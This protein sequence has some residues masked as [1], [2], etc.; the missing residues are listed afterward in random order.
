MKILFYT[1]AS[2]FVVGCGSTQ[3]TQTATVE[4]TESSK[5]TAS[6][7]TFTDAERIGEM[8]NYLASNDLKGR[9]AGSEGIE[10]AAKYIENYFKS[11]GLKPYFETYRDTFQILK[12][13]LTTL[14]G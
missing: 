9:E 10:M 8:M 4:T 12:R 11:Y 6:N 5:S 3:L 14:L 2:I 1:L 7:N 13:Q